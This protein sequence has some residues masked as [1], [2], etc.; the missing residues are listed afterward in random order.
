M[1]RALTQRTGEAL[2]EVLA[3]G[4]VEDVINDS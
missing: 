3:L 2:I 1:R 4:A